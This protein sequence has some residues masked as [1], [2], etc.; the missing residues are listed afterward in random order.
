MSLT[1]L[2]VPS[3]TQMLSALSAWLD[4]AAAHEQASVGKPDALL[5]LRLAADMYPLAAQVRFAC[6]QA[7]EPAH[8]LRGELLPESLEELRREGWNAN[9]QPGSLGNAHARIAETISFLNGVEPRALDD[10]AKRKIALE[11]PNGMVFDLT[12]EQYARDWAL[13]QFYFHLTTAYAILRNHGVQLGKAD[14]VSH[15]FAYFRPGSMPQG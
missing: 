8:R 12:G 3:F 6:F 9:S 15:M 11:L 14:Y 13:P 7:R 4:K 10:G 5:S 2:L 1:S